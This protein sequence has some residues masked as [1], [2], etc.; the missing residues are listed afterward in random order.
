MKKMLC[1]IMIVFV[2]TLSGCG[3][4]KLTT[5]HEIDYAEYTS[6]MENKETFP[7]VIGSSTCSAC[8]LFKGTMESFISKHQI[9][10]RYIDISKLSEDEYKLLMS[11]INFKSTPT[12]I[13]VEEGKHTSIYQRIVGAE[14]M[15]NVVNAYTKMGYIGE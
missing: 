13:F 1:L 14:S 5:Y 7:L 6:L 12:T 15:S 10:V 3:K 2:L 11:E 9:D 8:A 4:Q